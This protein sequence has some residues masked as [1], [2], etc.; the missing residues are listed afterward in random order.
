MKP[1]V[2][3]NSDGLKSILRSQAMLD[4]LAGRAQRIA[5][6]AGP[7]MAPSSIVGRGRALAMVYTDTDEARYNEAADRALTR[8]IDAGR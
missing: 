5:N 6:A 4:D 8:A 3:L 7:G 1:R 2:V